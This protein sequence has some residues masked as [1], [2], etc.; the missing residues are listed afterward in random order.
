MMLSEKKNNNNSDFAAVPI[1]GVLNVSN[2]NTF[3][4]RAKEIIFCMM[5]SLG[6]DNTFVTE[7]QVYI[8]C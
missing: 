7:Y 8:K 2:S 4:S 3:S 6:L 5:S 1:N